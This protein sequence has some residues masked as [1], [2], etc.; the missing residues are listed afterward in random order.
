MRSDAASD[1]NGP[2][3][4]LRANLDGEA[5]ARAVRL[6]EPEGT[7]GQLEGSG[8]QA[9]ERSN[10]SVILAIEPHWLSDSLRDNW[11]DWVY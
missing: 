2:V 10:S 1:A 6:D 7:R 4:P 8:L 9:G 11:H 3:S 5:S